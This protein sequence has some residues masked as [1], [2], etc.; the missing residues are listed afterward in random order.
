MVVTYKEFKYIIEM[1][2]WRNAKYH[3][4][5]IKQLIDYLDIHDLNEADLVI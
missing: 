5:E 2:I 3:E 4:D 1:K